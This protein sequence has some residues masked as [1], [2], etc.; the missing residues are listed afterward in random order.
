MT[1]SDTGRGTRA[2]GRREGCRRIG[3]AVVL[4]LLALGGVVWAQ[5]AG[6]PLPEGV[7]ARLGLGRIGWSDQAIAFSPRVGKYLAVATSIGIKLWD[8]ETLNL[9][10]FFRC[11]KHEDKDMAGAKKGASLSEVTK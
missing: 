9:V 7:V 5:E 8:V 2:M 6:I 4:F 3:A 1:R 11:S 10:Q